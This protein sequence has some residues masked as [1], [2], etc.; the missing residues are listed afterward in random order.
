MFYPLNSNAKQQKWLVSI[1]S[2]LFN[3]YVKKAEKNN[4]VQQK[5]ITKDTHQPLNKA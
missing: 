3:V 1:N 4:M 5:N 2:R